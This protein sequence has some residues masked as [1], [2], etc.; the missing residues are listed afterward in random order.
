MPVGQMISEN[1]T[2]SF[3]RYWL[4]SWCSG[5]P[6]DEIVLDESKALIGACVQAF[7]KLAGEYCQFR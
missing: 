7:A 3:L 5:K 1:H 6:P 2:I 4:S